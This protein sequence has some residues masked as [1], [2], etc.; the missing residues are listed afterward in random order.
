VQ[1]CQPPVDS[2]ARRKSTFLA[3]IAFLTLFHLL[4]G[5]QL[6]HAQSAGCPPNSA[7]YPCTYVAD[8]GSSDIRILPS[9]GSPITLT[10][11]TPQSLAMTPDNSYVWAASESSQNNS[12]LTELYKI[13]T[14]DGT[15]SSPI[16]SFQ[17]PSF[18][19]LPQLLAIVPNGNFLYAAASSTVEVVNTQTGTA[20]SIAAGTFN[21]LTSFFGAA[22]VAVRGQFVYVADYCS[23]GETLQACV[24]QI[25]TQT[26]TVVNIFALPTTADPPQSIAISPNGLQAY[27]A[28]ADFNG[29]EAFFAAVY[30][31][32]LSS[33]SVTTIT[34]T[35]AVYEDSDFQ[36]VVSPDGTQAYATVQY[37]TSYPT[38]AN[39]LYVINT[40]NFQ[41]QPVTVGN[42]PVGLTFSP[43]GGT[44]LVADSL[45]SPGTVAFVNRATNSVTTQTVGT[46]PVGI[47]SMNPAPVPLINQPFVPDA[48]LPGGSEFTLTVNGT[49]FVSNSAVNW[50]GTALAT[51]FVNAAQLTAIVPESDIANAGTASVTVTNPAP[52]GGTS[53]TVFFP[54]TSPTASLVLSK[55]DYATGVLPWAVVTADF[56][57]D[58]K[59]DL[60]V[61]NE[62]G[63][64]SI[65]L[66]NGDGT[67]QTQKTFSAGTQPVAVTAADF[68]G[69]G[70]LDLA[71]ANSL[72]NTVSILLGNGD[73]TF[74]PQTTFGTGAFPD[75]VVAGD[76]NGD[77]KLDLAVANYSDSTVSI[78]LGN[79]DGTFQ[80]QITFPTGGVPYSVVAGDFNGDGIL[81]LAVA[82]GGGGTVAILLGNG[83]GTFQAPSTISDPGQPYQ[84]VTAD[85]NGDGKLDLAVTNA[86]SALDTVA[87]LLGNGDGT[88]Q[89]PVAYATGK[90]PEGIS[91]AD[92][93]GDGNL[94]LAV[95]NQGDNTVSVLLG[96]GDGTFQ[97]Q[98]VFPTSADP[99]GI[100][101][102]DFN[103][104]G[105]LDL[106][107][108]DIGG[109][110]TVSVLLQSPVASLTP[111]ALAFGNQLINTASPPL[112]ATL[113][114]NGS[115][116]LSIASIAVG[117]T[118][119]IDFAQTNDCGALLAA[120][121]DCTIDV[122]FTPLTVGSLGAT[123]IVADNASGSPQTVSLSGVGT[124]NATAPTI[125]T[126][127]ASQ[128]INYGQTATLTVIAT[129]T[130]ALS[131]QWYL[132]ASGD[133][134]NPIAGATSAS[135]TTP[136]LKATTNYWVQVSNVA[137]SANSQTAT[138]TVELLVP[139]CTLSL[140]T[141]QPSLTVIATATC[142]DPQ[143]EALTI[144]ITW[145]DGSSTPGSNG[146]HTYA[147]AGNY[148]ITVTA[149]DTSGRQGI[150]AQIVV[151]T[152]PP[153][154]AGQTSNIP[155]SLTA[156]VNSTANPEVKFVCTTVIGPN[157][158]QN[159]SDAGI[160]CTSNPPT[161]TLSGT[162]QNVT[163]EITT[164]GATLGSLSPGS[165]RRALFYAVW[166]PLPGLTFVCLGASTFR[167]RRRRSWRLV[168]GLM[169]F[170]LVLSISCGGGFTAPQSPSQKQ[171]TA[172]GN[173][174]VKVVDQPVSGVTP[175]GFVQTSLIVPLA[176]Q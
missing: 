162:P 132:G 84:I 172:A 43:D 66:G 156:P 38:A 30:V 27:V 121:A 4:A 120:G 147:M 78:L 104:D 61:A 11:P 40:S 89:S 127:P 70:K 16:T 88:F 37:G 1:T 109:T 9:T 128:N 58:G 140:Q 2:K 77:G 133:T 72:D 22:A 68:I 13:T 117:G 173:Y 53:N 161:V 54:V 98:M 12:A 91:T 50:N 23:S 134:T 142:T 148:T 57:R 111:P 131:Y 29:E 48:T 92:L 63:T 25:D 163:I 103:Q 174:Q 159:A 14:A 18:Q 112:L 60:A 36:V 141:P 100:A 106:V 118:N 41:I 73:G 47:A 6:A 42:G 116:V 139:V 35:S 135:F 155:V 5:A 130:A 154:T 97:A 10:F 85:F 113:T 15:I 171:S 114:N 20:T 157:G 143:G 34:L 101:V 62:A 125:T 82:N 46:Y 151:Q 119:S 145:G 3:S 102:G 168:V 165:H 149:T 167:S 105:R 86:D 158:T 69:N 138:I 71:V 124:R 170:L 76:F 153:V 95:T 150:A 169:A 110:S 93:N 19:D 28:G 175:T 56:N 96:N 146:S 67:F 108:T 21:G 32:N 44:V 83:D 7:S 17:Y 52:V 160:T 144:V 64:V 31:L 74:Q 26:N 107:T 176:V 164:T 152:A 94:D 39:T 33:G 8:Y 122:T 115:A 24:D 80:P 65:L 79:G 123:L 126:Q 137:G 81:D 166:L 51:T 90:L 75:S 87:I 136:A 59:L 55:T 129:G 99:I 49:R 45:D